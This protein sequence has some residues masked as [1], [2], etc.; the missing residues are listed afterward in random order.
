MNMFGKCYILRFPLGYEGKDTNVHQTW[1]CCFILSSPHWILEY[2][3]SYD[4]TDVSRAQWILGW[5]I[6][7]LS[8][9]WKLFNLCYVVVV[10]FPFLTIIQK[11]VPCTHATTTGGGAST[12]QGFLWSKASLLSCDGHVEWTIN[13][14][15]VK[16]LRVQALW[17]RYN[18]A[19]TDH[20]IIYNAYYVIKAPW[21]LM[22]KG[23][24]NCFSLTSQMYLTIEDPPLF[25]PRICSYCFDLAFCVAQFMK[26]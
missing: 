21:S 19:Y 12:S 14:Y 13:I 26:L 4:H 10:C 6:G 7:K 8:K 9:T 18:P 3:T 17:P 22:L 2:V 24:L 23:T 20:T 25:S 5:D 11:E 1:F 15:C 16:P